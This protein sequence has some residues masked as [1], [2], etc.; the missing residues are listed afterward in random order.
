MKKEDL[1]LI[2]LGAG[3]GKRYGKEKQFEEINGIPVILIALEN[4]KEF[5]S[6]VYIVLHKRRRLEVSYPF[7]YSVVKGGEKRQDSVWNALSYINTDFVI[8]HDGAR[9]L[10]SEEVI[11]KGLFYL[12]QRKNAI[13][14]IK[15]RDTIREWKGDVMKTIDREFLYLI[16]T[17]QFFLTKDI[18]E[19]Y[20]FVL[21][22]KKEITDDASSLEYIGKE[23]V[24]FEGD[25]ENIKVTYKEDIRV[26]ECLLN[27]RKKRGEC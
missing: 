9:P 24:I 10:V 11:Q 26:V 21:K 6:N 14:G 13:P 3:R 27:L 18:K 2:L 1:S 15:V 4:F 16:Q 17:P 22:N 23:F 20:E 12:K 7:D 5:V 19:G 8:I 25:P